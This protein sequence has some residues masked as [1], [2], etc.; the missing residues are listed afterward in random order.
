MSKRT[1]YAFDAT[2]DKIDVIF[3]PGIAMS[4]SA[5]HRHD[6]ALSNPGYIPN[7]SV[8]QFR[9]TGLNITWALRLPEANPR[10]SG[11]QWLAFPGLNPSSSFLRCFTDRLLRSRGS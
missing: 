5:K 1:D 8:K 6:E 9:S 3:I 2:V 4:S 10:N 7:N 11:S